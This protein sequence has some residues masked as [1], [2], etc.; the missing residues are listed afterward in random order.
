M[1]IGVSFYTANA[2][3]SNRYGTFHSGF[4]WVTLALDRGWREQVLHDWL[5]NDSFA[6]LRITSISIVGHH[7]TELDTLS[8]A[9]LV[10]F[11]NEKCFFR[12][13]AED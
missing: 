12:S 10:L 3:Q 4:G 8:R 2:V 6:R 9:R 11:G 7:A 5:N 13:C 1:V